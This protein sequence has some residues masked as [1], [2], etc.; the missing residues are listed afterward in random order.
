ML[1]ISKGVGVLRFKLQDVEDRVDAYGAW[2]VQCERHH[3]GL[4]NNGEQADLL[5]SQ[6]SSCPI[7]L[8]VVS[9]DISTISYVKQQRFHVVLIGILS[10]GILGV[11]HTATQELVNFVKVDS[12]VL[13][14]NIRYFSVWVNSNQWVISAGCKEWETPVEA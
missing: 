11:L 2:E 4:G 8:N 10:H 3:R 12:E 6:L 5:F 13:G 14:A 7:G 9:T 1:A